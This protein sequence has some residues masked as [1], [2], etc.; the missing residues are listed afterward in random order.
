MFYVIVGG[1]GVVADVGVGRSAL[2]G[3]RG[4]FSA[5]TLHLFTAVSCLT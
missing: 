1:L 5:V 4:C 2:P 3:E